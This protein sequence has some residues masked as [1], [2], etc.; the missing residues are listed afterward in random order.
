MSGNSGTRYYRADRAAPPPHTLPGG[1][2]SIITPGYFRAMGIPILKGRDFDERDGMR[3]PHVA[4]LN[5]TAARLFFEGEEPLG[6]R[7]K[8]SWNDAREVEVVGIVGDIRHS[9]LHT[10]P[11]PCLFMPNAQQPFPFSALVVRTLGDPKALAGPVKEQ[12]RQ[13]DPDQGVAEVRTMEELVAGAMSQPKLQ[14]MLLSIF[15]ILAVTL[16]SI[17]IYGV[18]AYSVTQ[19]TREI[20]V[21]IALGATPSSAFRMVLKEG[22]G[23][24]SIGVVIGLAAAVATAGAL[25]GL[26]YDT[27]PLDPAIFSGVTALLVLVAAAACAVPALRATRVDPAIVLREE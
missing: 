15:S 16:A 2:I 19:R 6:K 10:R 27:E 24:A 12:I 17:G 23:L 11:D 5:Q 8:V 3:A 9:Q 21:R 4:I 1:D 14:A 13:A 18:L 25:R 7:L 22:L 20:G 26:L